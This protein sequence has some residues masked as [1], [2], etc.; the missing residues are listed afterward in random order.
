MN[1]YTEGQA[2]QGMPAQQSAPPTPYQPQTQQQGQGYQQQMA[3]ALMSQPGL[4]SGAFGQGLQGVMQLMNMYKQMNP[5]TGGPQ[6]QQDS[7]M[8]IGGF[9]P[10]AG[11][12]GG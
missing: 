10:Q 3:Q 7:Q 12:M 6:I 2:P 5:G 1:P 4:A 11:G 8:P 9:T